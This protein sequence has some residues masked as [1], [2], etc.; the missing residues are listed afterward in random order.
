MSWRRGQ[1]YGQGLREQVVYATGR[2]TE[3]ARRFGVSP[4][5]VLRM[6]ARSD[7]LGQSNPG[8]ERS[9]APLRLGAP[10]SVTGA[11]SVLIQLNVV[12]P[13]AA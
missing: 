9:H 6:R 11:A 13:S 1:A 7:E 3:V 4:S 2:L 8:V 10:L 5:Y 12:A